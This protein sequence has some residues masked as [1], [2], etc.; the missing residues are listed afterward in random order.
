MP[1]VVYDRIYW[2]TDHIATPFRSESAANVL[3]EVLEASNYRPTRDAFNGRPKPLLLSQLSTSSDLR[4][5]LSLVGPLRGV[6][7]YQPNGVDF[8]MRL[9][10]EYSGMARLFVH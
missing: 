3:A 1:G 5:G 10:R 7:Q 6:K 4:A 9:S 8:S 2:V